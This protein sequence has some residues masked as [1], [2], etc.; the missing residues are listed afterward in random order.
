MGVKKRLFL[1]FLMWPL[2]AAF[3]LFLFS[4][5]AQAEITRCNF[6]VTPG[7]TMTYSNNPVAYQSDLGP[8]SNIVLKITTTLNNLDDYIEPNSYEVAICNENS[9]GAFYCNGG[10]YGYYT[11]ERSSS[12][13]QN[14]FYLSLPANNHNDGDFRVVLRGRRLGSTGVEDLCPNEAS[15]FIVNDISNQALPVSCDSFSVSP[16]NGTFDLNTSKLNVSFNPS[17]ISDN[18]SYRFR[19]HWLS[20]SSPVQTELSDVFDRNT[21]SPFTWSFNSAISRDRGFLGN[22]ATID[23]AEVLLYNGTIEGSPCVVRLNLN[24]ETGE[25]TASS[26]TP[27]NTDTAS[28]TPNP[29]D[30]CDANLVKNTSAYAECVGCMNKQG[31][32]TAV[33]C[34]QPGQDGKGI[35]TTVVR[36]AIGL[37]GAVALLIILWASFTLSISQG[38]PQKVSGARDWLT[39]AVMGLLFIIFGVTILQFIGVE[40]LRIPGFGG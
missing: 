33:G 29:Y 28:D 23:G 39:A 13:N 20:E 24:Q 12:G 27:Y 1:R 19:I 6:E 15:V 34:I 11:P 40:I 18:V 25:V 17:A 37:A 30:I 36:F 10:E 9:N 14:E 35:I 22:N 8:N 32:W 7:R 21:S 3:S 38:D 16:D 31:I 4:Q 5:P 26:P 2:L